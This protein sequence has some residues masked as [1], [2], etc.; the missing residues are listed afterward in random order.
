M[1]SYKT[2]RKM[3]EKLHKWRSVCSFMEDSVSLRCPISPKCLYRKC[4]PKQIK[5]NSR[6]NKV[7]EP[8]SKLAIKIQ[9]SGEYDNGIR[10]NKQINETEEKVQT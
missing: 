3:E 2:L 7:E 9:K 6:R 10:I 8:I 5:E 4:N 1:Q